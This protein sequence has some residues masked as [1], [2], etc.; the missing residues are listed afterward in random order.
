[1]PL[2]RWILSRRFTT[3]NGYGTARFWL[4][5]ARPVTRRP[6]YTYPALQNQPAIWTR[7]NT[8]EL[9]PDRWRRLTGISP[10]AG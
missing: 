6:H 8:C 3:W 5:Q 9:L 10:D 1:M 4:T 2:T 7:G